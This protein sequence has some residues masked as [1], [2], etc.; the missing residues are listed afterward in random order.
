MNELKNKRALC[1]NKYVLK[2]QVYWCVFQSSD[3]SRLASGAQG[4]SLYIIDGTSLAVKFFFVFDFFKG[5]DLAAEK[6][7]IDRFIDKMDSKH[8]GLLITKN[9]IT[10]ILVYE[11]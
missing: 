11:Y 5:G 10:Y 8:I 9:K 4:L 6:K 1:K 7:F 2:L 3:Y